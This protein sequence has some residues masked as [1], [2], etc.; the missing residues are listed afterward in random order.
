MGTY[1]DAVEARTRASQGIIPT[2]SGCRVAQ[3]RAPQPLAA[4]S[5]TDRC[6]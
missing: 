3:G 1:P 2:E 4:T 6:S 5:W